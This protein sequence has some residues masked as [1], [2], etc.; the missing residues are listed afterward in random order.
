MLVDYCWCR[1]GAT[2]D[3]NDGVGH[4]SLDVDNNG[5]SMQKGHWLRWMRKKERH[6]VDYWDPLCEHDLQLY[7][8][9][10]CGRGIV[11]GKALAK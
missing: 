8:V 5:S 6:C 10:V 7:E 2:V 3:G 1:L 11:T 9:V 4:S